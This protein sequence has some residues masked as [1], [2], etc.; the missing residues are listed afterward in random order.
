MVSELL[1][2]F[3]LGNGAILTNVC[4]LPLYPG[5]IAFLSSNVSERNARPVGFLLGFA[6]LGGILSMMVV[7][8]GILYAIGQSFARVLPLV[9][10]VIYGLVI[11]LGVLMAMGFNPFA[12]LLT[13][14]APTAKSPFAT[15]YLYGLMFGP[16]TL[17][18]T[19]PI[20]TAAF[21]LSVDSTGALSGS[22]LLSRLLYFVCFGLGFGWPLLLLPV[23]ARSAQRRFLSWTTKNHELLVRGSGGLLVVI[24]IFG[25]WTELLPNLR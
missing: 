7:I 1:Q 14:Q 12:R 15:A 25:I 5:T 20:I 10:P 19:G 11:V 21:V 13:P 9:L 18:C 3:V 2:A 17:P 8:G 23:L 16:M 4:M 24:G 22:A 6:V